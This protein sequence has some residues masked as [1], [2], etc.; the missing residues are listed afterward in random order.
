[1]ELAV[2]HNFLFNDI[3]QLIFKANDDLV[4]LIKVRIDEHKQAE[5]AKE[6]EQRERIRAEE[7]AKLAAAA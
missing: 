1:A 4:S 7:T 5:E 3:Q 2:D 6:L